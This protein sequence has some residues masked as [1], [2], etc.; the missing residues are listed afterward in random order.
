MARRGEDSQRTDGL[1][2]PLRGVGGRFVAV[3]FLS[4]AGGRVL[5]AAD[6]HRQNGLPAISFFWV[7]ASTVAADIIGA[8]DWFRAAAWRVNGSPVRFFRRG[9]LTA[10]GAGDYPL[11]FPTGGTAFRESGRWAANFFSAAH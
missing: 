3:A 5:P 4:R 9:W 11:S 1:P 2:V 6:G 10:I 8:G 7:L